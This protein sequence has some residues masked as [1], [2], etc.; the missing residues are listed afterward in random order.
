MIIKLRNKFLFGLKIY[1]FIKI[2]MIYS[3]SEII[4]MYRLFIYIIVIFDR[5]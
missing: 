1:S 3:L 5:N 4:Y 2:Y